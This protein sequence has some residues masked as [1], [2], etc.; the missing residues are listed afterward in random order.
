MTMVDAR[1]RGWY[2]G[3]EATE[4]LSREVGIPIGPETVF[5]AA[6]RP[7]SVPVFLHVPPNTK[8]KQGQILDEGLWTLVTDRTDQGAGARHHLSKLI[9]TWTPLDGITG[10]FIKRD[11]D[12]Q[13]P[14]ELNPGFWQGRV[15][16]AWPKGCDLAFIEED[17]DR[18]AAMLKTE[19]LPSASGSAN[20]LDKPL[21]ARERHTLLK[22]IIGLAELAQVDLSHPSSD[23][24][25]SRIES[26]TADRGVRV[27]E[28][29]VREKLKEAHNFLQEVGKPLK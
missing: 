18:L 23:A 26:V 21:G 14:R 27:P 20:A 19:T 8:D 28:R 16:G 17:L 13:S 9:N 29:T 1:F 25:A 7:N 10:A 5:V 24:F 15:S 6:I 3:G 11:G 22:M 12:K 4:Y 2:Y